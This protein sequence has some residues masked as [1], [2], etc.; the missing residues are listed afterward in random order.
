MTK[1]VGKKFDFRE[2]ILPRK[3]FCPT[4]Y[5]DLALDKEHD[6]MLSIL[7]DISTSRMNAFKNLQQ[8]A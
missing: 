3:S 1:N 4:F 6:Q 7:D 5:L 2:M 8:S